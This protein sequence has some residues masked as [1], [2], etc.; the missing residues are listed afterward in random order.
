MLPPDSLVLLVITWVAWW[1]SA[2]GIG[3]WIS[4]RRV[5]GFGARAWLGLF[6]LTATAM[7]LALVMPL[8]QVPARIAA[9]AVLGIGAAGFLRARLW[10]RWRLLAVGA[11]VAVVLGLLSSVVP[12]N[13]DLGLYHAGSIAYVR[14]GGTVIGLAN[15]HDR[16]GFSSSMWPL[17]AFLGLGIWDGGEF[18]LV[19]GLLAVMLISDLAARLRK[20]RWSNPSTVLLAAGGVLL[21]GAVLHYPG[22]LLASSAQDW[23]AAVLIVVSTAYLLEILR[24]SRSHIVVS[25][26]LLAAAMAGAMRPTGWV[27]AAMTL[28]VIVVALVQSH[29]WHFA[30]RH[31]WPSVVGASVLG[32]A[33]AIRDALTS[34]W[35]LFPAGLFPLPVSWR[36][37]DAVGTSRGITAWARTPFQD[38]AQ[39]MADSSWITGW[40][41]RLPTDWAVFSLVVLGTAVGLALVVAPSARSAVTSARQSVLLA[42]APSLVV[43]IAWFAVAPDPRFAWGPLLLIALVPLAFVA[44][45]TTHGG[46]LSIALVVIG[47]GIVAV[48]F[49]R[50]S[51]LDV[52]WRLQPLPEVQVAQSRLDDGT[53]VVVPVEGD[54]CWGEFP[55]CRPSYS[56]LGVE[57]RS[58]SW[59]EG[60]QPISRLIDSQE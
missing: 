25:V 28:V 49:L 5:V 22:R 50:G 40:L 2:L 14:E 42:L 44:P 20:R 23:A 9:W 57:L 24:G 32:I 48:A 56:D 46:Q 55:L 18:R 3:S 6:L 59:R 35:L 39:T 30:V 19:N 8:G 29:G 21:I 36:Y 17:S 12:S 16:F 51:P 4:G 47:I 54:Q 60:F 7:V 13:Y 41:A 15:L 1:M 53:E 10:M 52:S 43:L 27:F 34:G 11:T 58:E 45:S 37:P 31:L 33:T 38:S 26:S